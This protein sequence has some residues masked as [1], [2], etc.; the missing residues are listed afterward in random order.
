MKALIFPSYNCNLKCSHC[1]NPDKFRFAGAGGLEEWQDAIL[2]LAKLGATKLILIGGEPMM[3]PY[4]PK[5]LTFALKLQFKKDGVFYN[6]YKFVSIQTNGTVENSTLFKTIED[7][8]LNKSKIGFTVSLEGSTA[9]ENDRV[10]GKGN[11]EQALKTAKKW[12]SNGYNVTIRSTIFEW[13]DVVRVAKLAKYFDFNF[14]AVRLLPSGRSE[15]NSEGNLPSEEK[16]YR[17]YSDLSKLDSESETSIVCED[18]PYYLYNERLRN[19]YLEVIKKNGSICPAISFQE[20]AVDP[21]GVISVCHMTL[22]PSKY[23]DWIVGN[24]FKDNVNTLKQNWVKVVSKLKSKPLNTKCSN[25]KYSS[26]CNG[27][28]T[29]YSVNSQ[30]RGD[31]YCPIN[32]MNLNNMGVI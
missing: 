11:F 20:L 28:C 12:R 13:N 17:V 1:F 5:L 4:L 25:C 10:R 16:L 30:F 24:I 29:F 14:T 2:T 22:E 26:I 8:G 7:E 9:D 19:K 6:P 31:N 3:V 27:G 32:K 18:S 23:P 15:K 21:L